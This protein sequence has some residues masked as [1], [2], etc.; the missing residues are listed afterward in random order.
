MFAP[1][2]TFEQAV[3]FSRFDAV[4]PLA[5]CAHAILLEEQRWKSAEHYAHAMVAGTRELA[6]RIRNAPTALAAYKLHKPWYRKKKR[7]WKS[8]RRF[9]MTRALYTQVQMYP[10]VREFLLN[11]GERLLVESSLYDHY[12]GIGRDLRGDNM[13]GRIW[14]DIR[15]KL[16]ADAQA[17]G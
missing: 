13:T 4:H 11:T 16:R 3:I 14:M 6:E 17:E 1:D 10:R 7:G 12:W 15:Q 2:T 9:Y 5:T 8:R